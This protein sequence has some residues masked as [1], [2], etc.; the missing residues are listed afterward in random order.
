MEFPALRHVVLYD[1]SKPEKT[2]RT[3]P[4]FTLWQEVIEKA[5][6]VTKQQLVLCP[7][8]SFQNARNIMCPDSSCN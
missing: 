4:G 7:I 1:P 8:S 3:H 5:G 6:D 2:E